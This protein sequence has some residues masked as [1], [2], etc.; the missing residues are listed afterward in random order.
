MSSIIKLASIVWLY[1]LLLTVFFAWAFFDIVLFGSDAAG[2]TPWMASFWTLRLCVGV[3]FG[4]LVL[5]GWDWSVVLGV[6][7]D[8]DEFPLSVELFDCWVSSFFGTYSFFLLKSKLKSK[9]SGKGRT[10]L[11]LPCTKFPSPATTFYSPWTWFSTPA[12]WLPSPP[13]IVFIL[14]SYAIILTIIH[15]STIGQSLFSLFLVVWLH[16]T[17]FVL[18][19][20]VLYGSS[21]FL[22]FALDLS[23]GWIWMQFIVFLS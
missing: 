15:I 4:V 19:Q 5:L 11:L 2:A 14:P 20:T 13:W 22:R 18:L 17:L 8:A 21:F 6:I 9:L 12:T 16:Y 10:T 23:S 1:Q 3:I 7:V